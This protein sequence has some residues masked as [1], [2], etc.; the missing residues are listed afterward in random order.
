MSEMSFGGVPQPRGNQD[1]V[2]DEGLTNLDVRAVIGELIDAGQELLPEDYEA[3]R[4]RAR[5]LQESHTEVSEEILIKLAFIDR[6]VLMAKSMGIDAYEE[7][8]HNID[9]VAPFVEDPELAEN[10][11]FLNTVI[12]LTLDLYT[13]GKETIYS[14]ALFRAIDERVRQVKSSSVR[15]VLDKE[16]RVVGVG[17]NVEEII[18]DA[19]N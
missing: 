5:K 1:P 4:M 14:Q 3:I 11:E 18:E 15:G 10:K 8:I 9:L 2:I 19:I 17:N 6:A 12:A 13:S 7:G 16:D